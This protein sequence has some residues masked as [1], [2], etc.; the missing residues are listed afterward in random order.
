[1]HVRDKDSSYPTS[2]QSRFRELMLSSF[3][4]VEHV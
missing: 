1:M 2:L 4:A 3:T